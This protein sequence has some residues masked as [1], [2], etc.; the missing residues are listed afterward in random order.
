[1]N[2]ENYLSYPKAIQEAVGHLVDWPDLEIDDSIDSDESEDY[3]PE[4]S[5]ADET[6]L[7]NNTSVNNENEIEDTTNNV[8]EDPE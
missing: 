1:M 8:S 3:M 4:E 7:Q 2:Y 6:D 5:S